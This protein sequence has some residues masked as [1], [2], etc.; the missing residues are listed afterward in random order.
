MKKV[1][2]ESAGFCLLMLLLCVPLQSSEATE[3]SAAWKQEQ[4]E[5]RQATKGAKR[6]S[7]HQAFSLFK[8]GSALLI[9]ADQPEY[10]ELKHIVGGINIPF[11]KFEHIKLKVP[12]TTPILI[13]CR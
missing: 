7:I 12:K 3:P 11:E 5:Y 8:S 6:I 9:S 13:Y 10:Y 4:R 1:L 2:H